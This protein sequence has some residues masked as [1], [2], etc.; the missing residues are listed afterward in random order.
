MMC[1]VGTNRATIGIGIGTILVV[2]ALAPG[3][4]SFM[5]PVLLALA[6]LVILGTLSPKLPWLNCLPK[7]GAPQVQVRVTFGDEGENLTTSAGG[8]SIFRIGIN[9]QSNSE[10]E[11]PRL[12]VLIPAPTQIEPSN[13][14]GVTQHRNAQ[15]MPD[16]EERDQPGQLLTFWFER[17]EVDPGWTIIHYA[18][19]FQ[20]A[21][22]YRL[23]IKL[24]SKSLYGGLF[25]VDRTVTVLDPGAPI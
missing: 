5:E 11:R 17:L 14:D 4:P 6:G 15:R 18:M 2:I 8:T 20:A 16:T 13:H 10:L 24:A 22:T 12:N 1:P 3:G 9:N 7:I 19:R 21:G 25:T 23:R